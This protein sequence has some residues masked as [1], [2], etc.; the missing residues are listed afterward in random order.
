MI[1][2][3]DYRRIIDVTTQFSPNGYIVPFGLNKAG[4]KMSLRIKGLFKNSNETIFIVSWSLFFAV[5]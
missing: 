4:R 1:R 3:L 2:I 5:E